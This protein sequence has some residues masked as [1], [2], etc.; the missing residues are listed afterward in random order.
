MIMLC[1]GGGCEYSCSGSLY[2]RDSVSIFVGRK[3]NLSVS[4]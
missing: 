3:G 1:S 2:F 4:I